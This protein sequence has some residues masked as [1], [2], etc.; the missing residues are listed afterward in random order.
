MQSY[1]QE[2]M[3]D[4]DLY[5]KENNKNQNNNKNDLLLDLQKYS[6]IDDNIRKS[7]ENRLDTQLHTDLNT[8]LSK[9]KPN[10][11]GNSNITKP[12]EQNEYFIPRQKDTLF[13]CFFLMKNGDIKYETTEKNLI[14]EKRIKIEYV[15]KIR[16]EK[17]L[18]KTYKFTTLTHIENQLVNESCIDMPTFLTLCVLENLNVFYIKKQ[19]YY[20]LLMNDSNIIY[21]IRLLENGKYCYEINNNYNTIIEKYRTSLYKMDNIDKPVKA[22][23]SYKLSELIDFCNKLAIEIINKETGKHKSKKDLYESIIQYF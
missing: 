3:C 9:N 6:F 11:K 5:K 22:F 8:N 16:K 10:F 4:F 7:I 15:E 21:V 14:V 17:A 12:K 23:S 20:E 2:I 19:V 18:I 13:W 1:I